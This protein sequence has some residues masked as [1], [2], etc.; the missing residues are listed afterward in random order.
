MSCTLTGNGESTEVLYTYTDDELLNILV[1]GEVY[2][3]LETDKV[4]FKSRGRDAYITQQIIAN[5]GNHEIEG[6]T[7]NGVCIEIELN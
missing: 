5:E 1:G 4:L 3:E 6:V 7:Y 2:T